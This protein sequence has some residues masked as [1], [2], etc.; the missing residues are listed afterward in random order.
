MG[1]LTSN[2]SQRRQFFSTILAKLHIIRVNGEHRNQYH[3]TD[4]LKYNIYDPV[5][6]KDC[7]MAIPSVALP[8]PWN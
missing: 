1:F 8:K 4:F 5:L 2:S 6:G 3:I 7:F